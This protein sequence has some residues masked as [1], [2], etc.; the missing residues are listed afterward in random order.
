MTWNVLRNKKKFNYLF[1]L[2]SRERFSRSNYTQFW[3]LWK[4]YALSG[5]PHNEVMSFPVTI[6]L[7][8]CGL[9]FDFYADSSWCWIWT[10]DINTGLNRGR[11]LVKT[12][13]CCLWSDGGEAPMRL[14]P[15]AKPPTFVRLRLPFV[16]G[17][18]S[19]LIICAA[20][21]FY[22][23]TRLK[24]RRERSWSASAVDA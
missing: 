13:R 17:L 19:R 24:S 14:R 4:A 10:S 3:A 11:C 12:T 18:T 5:S 9:V 6:D 21:L 1:F 16:H 20:C 8:K 7:I 15:K 23:L 2:Y 22:P